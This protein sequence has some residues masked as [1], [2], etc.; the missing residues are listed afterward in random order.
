[1]DLTDKFGLDEK[2]RIA[3]LRFLNLNEEDT[4]RLQ[5]IH[6]LAEKQAG[7]II[8]KLYSHLLSF[9]ETRSFF[10]NPAVLERVKAYQRRYFIELTEG[11][12]DRE[13]FENRLRVGDAHQR[14][15]LLPQWYLGLYSL[16]FKLIVEQIAEHHGSEE[17]L[18]VL[19]SL[20]K[21]MFLDIGLAFDA[22]IQGAFIEKLRQ[23]RRI[24]EN[25]R[26][27]LARKEKLAILGQLAG[28]VGHE[29]RNPMAAITASVYLLR[30]VLEDDRPMVEKHLGLIEQELANA[31]EIITNLLD[32][33]RVRQP[34]PVR[35]EAGALINDVLQ[36]Q[37]FNGIAV[38]KDIQNAQLIADPLQIRQVLTNLITNAVQAMVD[39]G[40]LLVECRTTNGEVRI[41]V[42]DNGTGIPADVLEKIFQPLF[43]TKAKGIGLGLSVCESLVR[44]NGGRMAVESIPGQGSTFSVY[45]KEAL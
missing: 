22:Y 38:E 40:R 34:E 19:P 31:N 15:E 44:A 35:I 18:K 43:T 33:S 10:K 2:E 8:E 6:A 39:G 5:S 41:S 11:R 45:L 9:E 13:Y 14:I 17:A 24:S 28:G 7:E 4:K 25:L 26:A 30:M 16:Y 23:E 1:M 36:R 3:R 37:D 32:F 21:Q 12:T 20:V 42:Q 27:E 29:L